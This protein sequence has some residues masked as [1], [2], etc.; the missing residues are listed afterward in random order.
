M[1]IILTKTE[2]RAALAAY[3]MAQIVVRPGM[4]VQGT[5]VGG[6]GDGSYEAHVDIVPEATNTVAKEPPPWAPVMKEVG[7][8]PELPK[9]VVLEV[10]VVVAEQ[11]SKTE[12]PQPVGTEPTT[13]TSNPDPVVVAEP[14]AEVAA[15]VPAE[16]EPPKIRSLF[17]G[18]KRPNN[19]PA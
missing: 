7:T 3:V 18:L 5:I 12:T 13:P 15:E 14:V 17:A 2:I 1:K 16:P 4:E 9:P 8:N 10:P 19:A 6:I 11:E